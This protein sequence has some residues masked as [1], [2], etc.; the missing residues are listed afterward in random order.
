VEIPSYDFKGNVL[1]KNRRVMSSATLKAELD[2]YNTFI[3]DWTGLPSIL[4][5]T[6]FTSDMFYDA[7]NRVTLLTLPQDVSS[8]RKDIV[9]TYNKS[10][11]L[12]QVSYDG[13]IYVENIVYDAKGQRLLIAFGNNVMTRYAYDPRIFRLLR[14]RSEKYSKSVVGNTITYNY[15]AGTLRQDEGFNNYLVGNI[16]KLLDRMKDCGIVTPDALDRNFDYDPIYRLTSADGRES[17]T[18]S[19]NSY[20]YDDAPA[21]SGL[22]DVRAYGRTYAYDKLGNVQSVVQSGTNGFTRNFVYN[23][24]KNTLQ[25]INTAAPALIEDYT[26]DNCGNQLTAGSTR[27]YKWNH[28]DQLICYYNQAGT[29]DP[30]IYTQYDYSGQDRVSKLV[31][32]GTNV[33]PIYERTIYIDGIFEYVKLENGTTYEKNYIHIMDDKSRIAEIRINV[34][35]AFPGDIAD[36]ITYIIED[37]IG[38]SVVRL[39][40]SGTV[41]DEEEYYPFGDSSLRTFTYKRYR[42]VGKERDAE[43]GLYY[44]GA[45]YYAAWTCRFISVDPLAAKYANLSPYNYADNNPINDYDIDGMQNNNSQGIPPAAT[46]GSGGS[47]PVSN[48]AGQ[49][50]STTAKVDV[51]PIAKPGIDY[52]KLKVENNDHLYGPKDAQYWVNKGDPQM[53]QYV[54]TQNIMGQQTSVGMYI[55]TWF[56]GIGAPMINNFGIGERTTSQPKIVTGKIDFSKLKL[57]PPI[58]PIEPAPTTAAPSGGFKPEWQPS[59]KMG[60]PTPINDGKYTEVKFNPKGGQYGK[61]EPLSKTGLEKHHMPADAVSP[62]STYKGGAIQITME[63]HMLTGSYGGSK[64]AKA[65]RA[66]QEALINAGDFKAAFDMDVRNIQGL[67]GTKYDAAISQARNYYISA[68]LFK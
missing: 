53:A 15:S 3:V 4:D 62:L 12:Q 6:T 26:Y 56:N 47:I 58:M 35:T 1:I 25:E 67:F 45:R 54:Q 7:L 38:S 19:G 57:S 43:S 27:N 16:V 41:I 33:S 18:Q 11:S 17:N 5:S 32:T 20:L 44:Y 24:G 14:Q 22:T 48:G 8:S 51:T 40:T 29:S 46:A 52:T 60:T 34:G 10:G 64:E 31:R 50:N 30:T 2:N 13:T 36:D 68:G 65:Y 59:Q 9:P 28:T 63:D 39:N 23:T 61:L 66:Q 37:Q 21:P 42:Y 55:A 49:P